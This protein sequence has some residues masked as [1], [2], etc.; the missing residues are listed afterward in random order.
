[1]LRQPLRDGEITVA[2]GGR[3]VRF[4]AVF[5]LIAGM[6]PCTCRLGR[7]ACSPAEVRRYRDRV[8]GTV[9][10]RSLATASTS[11]SR[12][13]SHNCHCAPRTVS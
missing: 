10:S 4:P 2:R 11:R 12:P 6:A 13:L 5:M 1:M 9:A 8:S 7:L 3:I